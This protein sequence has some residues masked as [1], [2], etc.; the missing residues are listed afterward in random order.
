MAACAQMKQM[1]VAQKVFD[2][3]PEPNAALWNSMIK[4]YAENGFYVKVL[5]LFSQMKS[6]DFSLPNCF[7]FPIVLKSCLKCNALTE[8]EEVHCVVIKSGFKGNPFVGTTLIEMYSGSRVIGAAYRVFSEMV[9]RNVVAWT[10]IINGFILCRDLVKARCL[11][12]LAPER[13]IVLWNIMVSGYIGT[14]DMVEARK[15]FDQMP[16]RDVMSWNTI[17]HG[18]ASNGDV[19]ACERLFEEMPERNVFSW[20]GLIGGYARNECFLE[21]LDA[22]KRMLIDGNVLPNDATLVTLL[23]AC[24]RLGALDLGKWVHVYAEN[25][26]YKGNVYVGNALIDLYAKCGLIKNAV[27]VFK[28][29]DKKDLISWNTIIGGLAMHGRGADALYL[30][31]QM[32]NGGVIPDGITFIGVLCACTH[33]GLV[34]DGIS[35]FQSMV[36]DYSIEPQIEHYGCMVDLLARAGLLPQAMDFVKKMPMEA[37]AVIWAAILGACRV[38]KNVEFAELALEQLIKFEPNNP[39]NFVMLANIY[40]DLGRWKDVARLKI[41]MRDTG[42]KKVPGCSLIEVNDD[43]VEFYS[44]DERHP[45]TKEI[46]GALRGLTK[47]LRSC[48]YIP[49]LQELEQGG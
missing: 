26:G 41:A 5:F 2:K 21:V 44:L 8:G 10:S 32:K 48:G 37:D 19:E 31:S 27:D 1:G 4:G 24:A 23:S 45:E 17:L 7:T 25:N 13:D 12:D 14:G 30:F 20:N 34:E 49:D 35:Y 47:L 36:D 3:N 46:Y 22:F 33:T 15:L 38:Y 18:Y 9:D 16:K 6:M 28:S 39:A 29:M 11:F 42:Y 43:V 40:G